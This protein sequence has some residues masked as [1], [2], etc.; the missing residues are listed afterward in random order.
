MLTRGRYRDIVFAIAFAAVAFTFALGWGLQ[1]KAQVQRERYSDEASEQEQKYTQIALA[2]CARLS[3]LDREV[4]I[5]DAFAAQR[6]QQRAN[7]DLHA[8]MGMREAAFWMYIVG[9]FQ[10][11][12]GTVGLYFVARTL[13]K[14]EETQRVGEAQV[15]AYLHCSTARFRRS[16]DAITATLKIENTG[17]S[18]ASRISV[19]GTVTLYD[20]GGLPAH[21]RVLAWL[22]S[23][24]GEVVVEPVTAGGHGESEIT[25][26][27]FEFPSNDDDEIKVRDAILASAN[28]VA[29][30]L[31]VSWRD[32]FGKEQSF[33]LEL[34][35]VIDAS[36]NNPD[37]KRAKTGNL[38]VRRNDTVNAQPDKRDDR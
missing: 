37:R 16:K 21:P 23:E 14:A 25:F 17:Q 7:Y 19:S 33:P 24:R 32:V 22:E 31:E 15:R 38:H 3:A 4:C 1:L 9:G 2:A 30:D 5:H 29:F 26:W 20:V 35:A 12:F 28:E 6:D 8:Q 34:T 27:D 10:A 36:P 11:L 18:P 13:D